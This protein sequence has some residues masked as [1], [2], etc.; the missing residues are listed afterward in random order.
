MLVL[1]LVAWFG[2]GLFTAAPPVA[3]HTELTSSDPSPGAVVP[4]SPERLTLR[5]TEGVTLIDGGFRLLSAD[6]SQQST[7]PP[8][9]SGTEVTVPVTSPLAD[10]AYI[11]VYRVSSADTHPIAGSVPF[12]VGAVTAD[13]SATE[14]A[15]RIVAQETAVSEVVRAVWAVDRWAGFAGVV[16]LLGV[17]A[18]VLLGWSAG[19]KDPVLRRL[20][21][22]S[23]DRS[24]PCSPNPLR[25]NW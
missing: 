16:L 11:L 23:A 24:G 14:A 13:A 9:A 19:A 20:L 25:T 3:A 12:T 17:P 15:E 6:A 21:G 5:F 4:Q 22:P 7:G 2:A 10:G 18:F 1:L 8:T